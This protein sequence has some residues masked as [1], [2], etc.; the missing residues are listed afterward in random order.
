MSQFCWLSRW[1]RQSRSPCSTFWSSFQQL[2][3]PFWQPQDP[4]CW[5]SYGLMLMRSSLELV[6]PRCSWSMLSLAQRLKSWW[7]W[8]LTAVWQFV[9]YSS[10]WPSWH[11]RCCGHQFVHC[12]VSKPAYTSRD[13]CHLLLTLL[14]VSIIIIPQTYCEHMGTAKLSCGNIQF[15]SVQSLSSPALCDPMDCSMSNFPVHH[16]LPEPIQTHVP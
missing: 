11:P 10:T 5:V 9:L 2:I 7:R 13:L 3:W 4:I 14:P 8:P 15:S 12:N 16:Q 6:W 1:T